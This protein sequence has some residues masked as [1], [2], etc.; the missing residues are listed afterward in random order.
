[1]ESSSNTSK[2]RNKSNSCLVNIKSDYF[3]Q[4]LYDNISKK[5]KFE[6]VKCNKKIQ[7]RLNLGLKDYKEYCET[8]TPIEMEIIPIKDIYSKF[9]NIDNNDELYYHIYFN[10]NKQEINNKYEIKE[11]DIVTKIK[12]I[13]DYQIISFEYLFKECRCIESINFKKFYRNNINNMSGMFSGCPSLKE[14]NFS[15]FNTSNVT[16]MGYMFSF[17]SSLKELNLSNF[18]TSKVDD[19][20]CMFSYCSSLKELNLSN[21]NT[22]NVTNISNMF[23]GCISLKK[24]NLSNF[25]TKNI[26]NMSYMFSG[27]SSLL[28]LNL[29]NFNT[30]NA[31]YISN[32]FSG[33]CKDLKK[34][35]LSENQNIKEE[36]F[37]DE[38]SDDNDNY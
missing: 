20:I 25:N 7:N 34:K 21:F 32:M 3:L 10:D 29:S 19:M 15:N 33:C 9:I 6:I 4:K 38:E 24:L 35:I 36:A 26:I 14:I 2:D 1:M 31:K 30:N 27:C 17:C 28:E 23:S 13:I 8:F 18:N 5:K 12:I 37:Y 16:D 11:E 22:N